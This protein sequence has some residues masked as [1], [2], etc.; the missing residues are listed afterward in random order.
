M[1]KHF[2]NVLLI[3]SLLLSSTASV[4]ADQNFTDIIS[5]LAPTLPLQDGHHSLYSPR[6]DMKHA[7]AAKYLEQRPFDMKMVKKV[8]GSN[9]VFTL[10]TLHEATDGAY[11][12]LRQSDLKSADSVRALQAILQKPTDVHVILDVEANSAGVLDLYSVAKIET[13]DGSTTLRRMLP[14]I[15]HLHLINSAKNVKTI[16][17][18]FLYKDE[19][20]EDI[21]FTGFENVEHIADGFML[22]C[23][24]LKSADLSSFENLK[25]IGGFF[26]SQA[27]A[28][29]T[30]N[31]HTTRFFNAD[32]TSVGDHF[33]RGTT[34][35]SRIKE[36][37]L[38]SVTN[39]GDY[40]MSESGITRFDSKKFKKLKDLGKDFLSRCSSLAYVNVSG[41]KHV[42]LARIT[43]DDAKTAQAEAEKAKR[44]SLS[45][46]KEAWITE[47]DAQYATEESDT[48]ERGAL[49]QA[50]HSLASIKG[51]VAN[52]AK[53]A[54]A[55]GYPEGKVVLTRAEKER[56]L[57]TKEAAKA[58]LM[59]AI[60][61]QASAEATNAATDRKVAMT[62]KAHEKTKA[63]AAHAK[64][65]TAT[66]GKLHNLGLL[67]DCATL[68]Q[69]PAAIRGAWDLLKPL[70]DQLHVAY[71]GL[72]YDDDMCGC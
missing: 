12:L 30:L 31:L 60:D 33:L 26:M 63:L 10:D 5:E 68:K 17:R 43:L 20:L 61:T 39:I 1:K 14:Y 8:T 38:E 2:R 69:T 64:A 32:L 24:N 65:L 62:E 59:A 16:G 9:Q 23:K 72:T 21:T 70:R 29:D 71:P 40:F 67:H 56:M 3:G 36:E 52:G 37:A 54:A 25:T 42:E 22:L 51:T 18:S 4:H 11:I 41:L 27:K 15:K 47:A 46:Y 6:E 49:K 57:A 58:I 34:S 53:R 19:Y 45:M 48:A 35:L 7:T 55:A 44:D 50:A 66:V 13:S 28:L